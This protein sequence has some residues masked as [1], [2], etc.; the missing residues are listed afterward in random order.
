MSSLIFIFFCF[1]KR[2]GRPSSVEPGDGMLIRYS[3][4]IGLKTCWTRKR[5]DASSSSSTARGSV[6]VDTGRCYVSL[7]SSGTRGRPTA[8]TCR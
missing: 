7:G 5:L 6:T 1:T 2:S 4:A 3:F 8:R